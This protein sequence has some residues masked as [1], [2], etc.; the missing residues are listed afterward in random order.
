MKY[1]DIHCHLNHDD[2]DLD[3]DE[4][5]ARARENDVGMIVVGNDLKTSE[6]A[7]KI[8]EENENIWAT[9]GLHP[10]EVINE[11]FD[12]DQYLKLAQN[13][14][15]VGIGECG[16]D[17]F[18]NKYW[19][20]YESKNL[21][22]E[23]FEKH[24]HIANEVKKP[25]MLHLRNGQN[26]EENA[27]IDAIDM[28]KKH[29]LVHGDVHFFSGSME[30]EREFIELGYRLSFT[31]VI[32]FTHDY[33]EIV[34]HTPMN[35]ILSETDAPLVSPIPHRGERNEPSYVI[36][37]VEAISRIKEGAVDNSVDNVSRQIVENARVLFKI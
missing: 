3:R 20:G 24:I 9:V 5:I 37:V 30:E 6:K 13:P 10:T 22:T 32:T 19:N 8:A 12:I 15:V 14:K 33:D 18:K 7:I 34:K 31:G 26:K 27:Y 4:V 29:A 2:Y 25:L 35:M 36:E 11:K 28:I 21:Q 23:L 1:I 17:Y 16:Y